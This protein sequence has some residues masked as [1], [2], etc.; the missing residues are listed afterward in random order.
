MARE[1][2]W[3]VVGLNTPEAGFQWPDMT[4]K[5]LGDRETPAKAVVLHWYPAEAN[6]SILP[7]WFYHNDNNMKSADRLMDLYERS[8]GHNAAFILNVPPDRRGLFTDAEVATLKAFGERRKGL[9]GQTLA[10]GATATASSSLPDHPATVALDGKYD[11]YWE[12]APRGDANASVTLEISLP[13]E[14]TFTRVVLQEQIRRV[15]Q[16]TIE[17]PAPHDAGPGIARL[18]R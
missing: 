8:V 12:A 14:V 13:R 1:T 17:G 10:T 11:T 6:V 2:E 5:L 18:T 15:S 4:G 3:S 9:Y 16:T 7:G